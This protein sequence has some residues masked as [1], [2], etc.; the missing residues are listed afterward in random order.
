MDGQADVDVQLPEQRGG[1]GQ[2]HVRLEWSGD[3]PIGLV[4]DLDLV[5]E[6][7]GDD[8]G[9]GVQI[10]DQRSWRA[11]GFRPGP[12]AGSPGTFAPITLRDIMVSGL[13]P[14]NPAAQAVYGSR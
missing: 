6:Q 2:R 5:T 14:K 11:L 12:A 3:V 13:A 8:V 1:D 9:I 10:T 4:G 7:R